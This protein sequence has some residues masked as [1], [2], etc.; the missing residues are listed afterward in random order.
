MTKMREAFPNDG[1]VEWI[2]LRPGKDELVRVVDTC[3]ASTELGL[4][5]DRFAGKTGAHRQVTLISKEHL[6]VVGALL[7]TESIDPALT[8]RNIVVSGINLTAFKGAE[9]TIGDA[10]LQGTG[11]CPPCN[12]MEENLGTGGLNAMRGHG[13]LTACVVTDGAISV[14]DRVQFHR[15]VAT[16]NDD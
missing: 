11:N 3:N 7:K 14:G 6:A 5:G 1:I 16:A 8:R 13:G 15:F 9:F 10:T 4:I 12:K 2:G